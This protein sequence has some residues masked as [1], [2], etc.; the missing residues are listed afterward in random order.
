MSQKHSEIAHVCI[1]VCRSE[2]S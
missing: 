2:M 1:C